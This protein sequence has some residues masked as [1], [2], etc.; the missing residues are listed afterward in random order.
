MLTLRI[1]PHWLHGGKIWSVSW[2]FEV[3]QARIP[4]GKQHSEPERRKQAGIFLGG[5]GPEYIFY[6]TRK[7]FTF[8]NPPR[9][10]T[11]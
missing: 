10:S 2:T 7:T 6:C 9:P 3:R 5:V 8:V 4:K 1:R 11:F